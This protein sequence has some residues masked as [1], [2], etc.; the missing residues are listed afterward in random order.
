[1][2]NNLTFIKKT[3]IKGTYPF[4]NKKRYKIADVEIRIVPLLHIYIFTFDQETASYELT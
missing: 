1:M 2:K 4:Y 3:K